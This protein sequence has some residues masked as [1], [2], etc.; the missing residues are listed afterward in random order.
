[1]GNGISRP[2]F[3]KSDAKGL[4]ELAIGSG[5]GST[6]WRHAPKANFTRGP[7]AM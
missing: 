5:S 6:S 3:A 1:V 4:R 2:A 7:R